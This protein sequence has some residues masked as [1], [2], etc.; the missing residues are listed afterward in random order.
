MNKRFLG[1]IVLF[2]SFVGYTQRTNTN[3]MCKLN[4]CIQGL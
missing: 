4:I 3:K 2:V 1:I